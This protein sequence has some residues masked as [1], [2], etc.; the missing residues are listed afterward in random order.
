MSACR[1]WGEKPYNHLNDYLRT[2]YGKKL[3]KL[4]ID[5][6]FTCPNRDGTVGLGGCTFCSASGSG[7]FA[8][9]RLLGVTEQLAQ[10]RQRLMHRRRADG[11][12]AYFQAF[13][14]TYG[15]MD[16][17]RALYEEAIRFPG[18]CILSVA[19]RPDCLPKDVIDLLADLN[20][21]IP[22][23]VELGLQTIHEDTARRFG[24][25]YTLPVFTDAVRRLREKGI[26]VIV[27]TI[28]YLPGEEERD[29][30][31]T[32]EFLNR[33][34]IQGIK[35][36][37][38]HILRGTPLYETYKNHP[39]YVPGQEEYIRLL[40]KIVV[41]LRPDITI[42][43]LTG[44]GPSDLLEA[45]LWTMRKRSVL[46]AIHAAFRQDGIWQGMDYKETYND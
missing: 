32:I 28:L 44:D 34:D 30:M 43:R 26:Y 5:G 22:V 1:R 15:P 29:M 33:T 10:Q 3:Y 2:T 18:V 35:L 7:D 14:N 8:G 38:L 39:F 45:P 13:T 42:H 37:L 19:T 24:R 40:E 12:I 41:R 27:H 23:W 25:G 16:K 46:N 6:G 20:R 17:L 9:S 31:D 11:Y 36:S 4:S 21:R